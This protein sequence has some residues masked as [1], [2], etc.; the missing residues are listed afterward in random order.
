MSET[1]LVTGAD[2]Y[3]GAAATRRF[4]AETDARLVLAVRATDRAELHRKR[5]ELRP[6]IGADGDRTEVIPADLRSVEPFDAL[7]PRPITRI[8]HTAA[9]TRFN[10]EPGVARTVNIEGSRKVLAFARRCPELRQVLALS[11]VYSAGRAEG[12]VDETPHDGAAGF[13]NA[14]EWS[15]WASEWIWLTAT[16]LP[17]AVARI[18]TV[19][20]DDRSGEVV[21]HNAFHNSFRLY[22]HGLLS[23]VPGNPDT[24]VYLLT[25]SLASDAIVHLLLD[26]RAAG[27]YHVCPDRSDTATLGELMD[28]V[29]D[30][31]EDSSAYRARRLLRPL[32]CDLE[33]FESLVAG[34]RALGMSPLAQAVASVAPFAAQ[35]YLAKDVDNRRLRRAFPTYAAPDP[36][37]LV[38]AT[39]AWLV[40]TRWGRQSRKAC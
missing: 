29:L 36:L 27:L 5:L 1:I 34:A 2:G 10:V 32:F 20:A 4:L 23:L 26:D 30:V 11:T 35:L 22:Y 24:P 8:L 17:V 38:R 18:G 25:S 3:L 6:L 37:A 19:I 9:V 14:Y 15:K 28:A 12:A 40:A 33:A 39:A 21:Q 13:V 16:D 31:F 7:D